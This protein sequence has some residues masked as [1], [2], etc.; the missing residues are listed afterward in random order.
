MPIFKVILLA[1]VQGLAE[2]LP[3]SSSAHVVVA[4]KLLGLDPSSPEMT[5]LLVMLHTGTMFAVIVYFWKT[6]GKTY[7][8]SSD[9]FKR[10]AIRVIWATLLTGVIGEALVKLIEKTAFAG[11]P[12]AEIELLFSRLDLIAPALAAAGVV[13][14]IAGLMERKQMAA[15]VKE[16]ITGS[17]GGGGVTMKQ[18]GWIGAVQGLALPFRGFSR[19]GS[20]I[21]AG[22]LAGAPKE[23]A[24]RFSFALAVVLTPLVVG[25]E[26]MRLLAASKEA[27]ALGTPIDLHASLMTSLLGMVFAF[28]GGL[29]GL[30]W[31][32]VWLESG[33]WYLFGIYCLVAS[34]VVFY[35]H[36]QGY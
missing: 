10:F 24:E 31:L 2:L 19:S 17:F 15:P 11:Q 25:R 13:I 6:W 7:F 18:A 21:S 1:I 34:C 12:K 27:A 35:L 28:L 5:L 20:T 9:A 23:R 30:K 8:S 3:V 29:I 32:S 36:T 4:E 26:A 22:M 33:K 16:S 14:L